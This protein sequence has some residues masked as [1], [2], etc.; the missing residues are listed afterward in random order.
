MNVS[1]RKVLSFLSGNAARP[2]REDF[3]DAQNELKEIRATFRELLFH[4]AAMRCTQLIERIEKER[5]GYLFS[6]H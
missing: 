4:D 1:T 3:L 2:S 5:N 6:C